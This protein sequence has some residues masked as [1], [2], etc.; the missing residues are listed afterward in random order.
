[1][2]AI[3]VIAHPNNT[4]FKDKIGKL[5]IQWMMA[6]DR[7]TLHVQEGFWKG[8]TL[9]NLFSV[10]LPSEPRESDVP[11]LADY[12]RLLGADFLRC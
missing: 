9:S 8:I 3:L 6:Q 4:K 1:M 10:F 5:Q 7:H 2:L 12:D 11:L